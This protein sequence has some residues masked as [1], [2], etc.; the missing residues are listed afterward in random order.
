MLSRVVNSDVARAV[1]GAFSTVFS[2][3][4]LRRAR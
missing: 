4:L 3:H 1:A 2:A